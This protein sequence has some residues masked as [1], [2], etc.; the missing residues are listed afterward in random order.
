MQEIPVRT[1]KKTDLVVAFIIALP[2]A[3]AF[4]QSGPTTALKGDPAH[5]QVLYKECMVC[6]S[7]DT[8]EV[9]PRHRGIVGRRAGSI[10][11]FDYSK[12]L[13][14]S[15]LI[16]DEATLDRW[17]TDPSALVPGTRMFYQVD[18]PQ[19]RADIVAYLKEQ[20]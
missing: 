13:K 15:G 11:G 2:F 1:Q 3:A 16:W 7:I 5:G 20:S 6:H 12:E 14:N 4:A 10:A 17:L 9:G 8:D 18:N 19:D